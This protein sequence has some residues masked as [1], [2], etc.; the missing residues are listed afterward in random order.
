MWV[1]SSFQPNLGSILFALL[2]GVHSWFTNQKWLFTALCCLPPKDTGQAFLG[3][4]KMKSRQQDHLY[5]DLLLVIYHHHGYSLEASEWVKGRIQSITFLL[6]FADSS[7]CS[8]KYEPPTFAVQELIIYWGEIIIHKWIGNWQMM[9]GKYRSIWRDDPWLGK[10]MGK[11]LRESRSHIMQKDQFG[12]TGMF[13]SGRFCDWVEDFREVW[14]R[15]DWKG[16]DEIP[17]TP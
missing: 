12:A 17:K 8:G 7:R 14:L 10:N 11:F 1:F 9:L 2:V 13:V 16:R 3:W 4:G 5:L 15:W 6:P